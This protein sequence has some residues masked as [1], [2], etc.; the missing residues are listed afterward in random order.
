MRYVVVRRRV[1]DDHGQQQQA[2]RE[3]GGDAARPSARCVGRPGHPQCAA[4]AVDLA[5][6]SLVVGCLGVV[7][8]RAVSKQVD[9][10]VGEWA[11]LWLGLG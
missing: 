1:D 4:I 11:G 7:G 9:T 5:E 3:A 8:C 6:C 10:C 2:A